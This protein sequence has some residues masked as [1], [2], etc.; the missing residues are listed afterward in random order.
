[1]AASTKIRVMLS[2]RCKDHFPEKSA[3]TLTDI[4]KDLKQ[5]IEAQTLLGRPIFEVWIN[6][7]AAPADSGLDS[8]EVC[9]PTAMLAGRKAAVILVC[10]M[11]STWKACPRR[12]ARSA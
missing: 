11:P 9:C 4:R 6:E 2:S 1:M 10:A 12:A 7:D 3:T 5:E 8:W